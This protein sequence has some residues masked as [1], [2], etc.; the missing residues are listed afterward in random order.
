[1]IGKQQ[2]LLVTYDQV[3]CIL[4]PYIFI[5]LCSVSGIFALPVRQGKG[6]ES[7]RIEKHIGETSRPCN[8]GV[9]TET[10]VHNYISNHTVDDTLEKWK[11]E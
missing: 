11:A 8:L 6:E 1:M 7:R 3:I 2:K 4:T 5:E 10:H 9:K